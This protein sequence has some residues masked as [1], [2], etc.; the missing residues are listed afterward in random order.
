[1]S[2]PF[3][4]RDVMWRLTPYQRPDEDSDL[5][6][7]LKPVFSHH[8]TTTEQHSFLVDLANA[9][10]KCFGYMNLLHHNIEEGALVLQPSK[11][12]HAMRL[13]HFWNCN[14]CTRVAADWGQSRSTADFT[15]VPTF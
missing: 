6:I 9:I 7:H 10:H 3:L 5:W 13:F 8:C 1:M 12:Q 2:V 4:S 11:Y 15:L 14:Q